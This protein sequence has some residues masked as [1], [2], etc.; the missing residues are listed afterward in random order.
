MPRALTIS[1][2]VVIIKNVSRYC[3][4]PLRG[5]NTPRW[6][7]TEKTVYGTTQPTPFLYLPGSWSYIFYLSTP[8]YSLRAGDIFSFNVW[9]W[10][11]LRFS[12]WLAHWCLCSRLN[13]FAPMLNLALNFRTRSAW[14]IKGKLY[15][16]QERKWSN[17]WWVLLS[18]WLLPWC[19][20]ITLY[21]LDKFLGP[22]FICLQNESTVD[23]GQ[24]VF[25]LCA[26]IFKNGF[27]Q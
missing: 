22:Q 12:F 7:P 25:Q 14:D 11:S 18:V 10:Y 24:C 6:E 21:Q 4:M 9:L 13:T 5:Q 26:P 27:F 3:Q 20:Y 15:N 1:F 16:P 8:C 2:P 19:F 23:F 17:L